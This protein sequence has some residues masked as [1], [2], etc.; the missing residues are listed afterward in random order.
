VPPDAVQVAPGVLDQVKV[1]GSPAVKLWEFAVNNTLRLPIPDRLTI[2]VFPPAATF[3]VALADPEEVGWNT[4]R[5]AQLA[6]TATDVPQ[7]LVCENGLGLCVE[8]LML[9]MGSD[10]VPVLVTVTDSGA[11]AMFVIWLPN[12][13][14]AGDIE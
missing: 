14:D 8:S 1:T 4:T 9:V 11:L 3:S 12:A 13:K 10:T 7:V 5:T 2:D 6:P